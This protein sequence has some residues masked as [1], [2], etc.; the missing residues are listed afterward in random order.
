[1]KRWTGWVWAVGVA[2]LAGCGA[3]VSPGGGADG[4]ADTAADT[5]VDGAVDTAPGVCTMPGG[6]T[7]PVG[8]SCPSPDGCNTCACGPDGNVACTLR[9]C[10]DAGPP[11]DVSPPGCALPRGGVCARGATCPA[12]DG[13]NTCTCDAGGSL[14]CTRLACIPDGGTRPCRSF[15]DCGRGEEC[16]GP[17]GCG[18]PWSCRPSMGCTPDIALFCGCD[19]VTFEGSSSCPGRPYQH[20]GR[21][22]GTSTGCVLRDGRTCPPGATCPAGDGCNDCTC[23]TSGE[24]RCT[25]RPC[26]PPRT[27][28]SNSDCTD[29]REC[30]GPEGCA[31]PW[32]CQPALGRPCTDDLAAFCGCDG[33]TLTGSSTCPPGPFAH[34]GACRG[35]GGVPPG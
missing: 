34:R 23:S 21:C 3:T 20:T 29:G 33:R 12:G 27:C 28:T 19:G 26:L 5:T 17:P 13:C 2:L 32:T 25:M 9:G 24:L 18:T 22:S 30:I 10:V 31:V 7:C 8:R 11:V 1:M 14:A 35:D 15:A 6:W 4:G 16:A